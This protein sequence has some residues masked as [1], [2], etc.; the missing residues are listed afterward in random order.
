MGCRIV[1]FDTDMAITRS[2]IDTPFLAESLRESFT[3]GYEAEELANAAWRG[4]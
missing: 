2:D 1:E 3:I 4:L